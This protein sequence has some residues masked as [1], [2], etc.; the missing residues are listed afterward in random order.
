MAHIDKSII[1]LKFC[2]NHKQTY[3][4]DESYLLGAP[5][6]DKEDGFTREKT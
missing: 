5:E 1:E 3:F 6:S 4:E 2:R